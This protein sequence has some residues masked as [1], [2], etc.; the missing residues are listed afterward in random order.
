MLIVYFSGERGSRRKAKRWRE[1]DAI[2]Y[3]F[4]LQ[5]RSRLLL[6]FHRLLLLLL[7]MWT[8]PAGDQQWHDRFICITALHKLNKRRT[9][10]QSIDKSIWMA[11]AEV[12]L[13]LLLLLLAPILEAVS[14]SFFH[15]RRIRSWPL[16]FNW[17]PSAIYSSCCSSASSLN[18]R[19]FAAI[20]R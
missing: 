19:A 16:L 2:A 17:K 7:N 15:K 11:L 9:P 10:I 4:M 13:R 8:S 20:N 1:R 3:S 18:R 12:Y 5:S 14:T 6:H